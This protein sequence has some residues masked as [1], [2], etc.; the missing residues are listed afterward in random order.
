MLQQEVVARMTADPGTTDYGRLTV[1]L[2]A[3]FRSSRLFVVPAGAFRPAPKV[4]SALARLVAVAR[5]KAADRRRSTVRARRGGGVRATA[6]D[7]A[8]CAVVARVSRDAGRRGHRSR[9]TR[10]DA[11]R[12]RLRAP[13]QLL[14]GGARHERPAPA[15]A[16]LRLVRDDLDLDLC[17]HHQL[18]L[19]RGPRGLVAGKEFGVDAVERP[20]IARIVEPDRGLHHVAARASG[21]RERALDIRRASAAPAPRCRRERFR[22]SRPSPPGPIRTRT[23]PP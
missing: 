17:V 13:R 14:S 2:Q 8:Q 5:T 18:G 1:M 16:A 15:P 9:R 3:K 22:R 7:V 21:Q 10:R 6:Q 23:V 11:C 19:R 12:R 20:E 4:E